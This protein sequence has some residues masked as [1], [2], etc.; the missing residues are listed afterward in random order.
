LNSPQARPINAAGN[1]VILA[2]ATSAERGDPMAEPFE[3]IM[4]ETPQV[5]CDG[6]GGPLGHPRIF[7]TIPPADGHVDCPYCSRRYQLKQDA[8]AASGH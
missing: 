2:A 3:L 1:R 4:V 6:G 7:M 8:L 5:A